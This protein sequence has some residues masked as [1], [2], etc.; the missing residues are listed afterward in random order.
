MAQLTSQRT[1]S[2]R[3]QVMV[4]RVIRI[5]CRGDRKGSPKILGCLKEGG[6]DP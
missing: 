2:L 6:W 5:T 4:L 3:R 1:I